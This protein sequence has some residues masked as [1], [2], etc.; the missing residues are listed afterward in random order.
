MTKIQS[1]ISTTSAQYAAN[2]NANLEQLAVV[3]EAVQQASLGG[4][5]GSRERHLSRGK[6]L[7]RDRVANLLDR[8]WYD[9]R[10]WSRHG[11]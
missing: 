2:E 8:R 5:E 11:A 3:K 4:G 1:K 10:H 9:C 7:P 6:M